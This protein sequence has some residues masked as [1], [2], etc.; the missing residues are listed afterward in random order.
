MNSL[1][2]LTNRFQI[3]GIVKFEEGPGGLIR[4]VVTNRHA[5][6][7]IYLHG[8]HV[9]T[10]QPR[11][12]RPVLFMSAAS[13]FAAG[14]PI[15]G[16]VPVI[17]PWFGPNPADAAAPAH[18]L[19]RLVDWELASVEEGRLVFGTSA[20]GCRLTYRVTIGA[21]L[22]LELEV[23]NIGNKTV[24]FE[25]ALHTYFAASDCRHCS[26]TGLEGTAYQSKVGETE[27]SAPIRFTRETDRLYLN[28]QA[29]CV[30]HD[31][32]WQRRIIVEKS[33]SDCTV[34]WNPWIAKAKAMPDFGDD[35][36]LG[37]VCIEAVNARAFAVHL[38][39]GN[40]HSLRQVIRV[41]SAAG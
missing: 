8:A 6:A 41:E 1:E 5:E 22:T 14:K 13:C 3:P 38:A 39:P 23:R 12:H 34:V 15:R 32:G 27:G 26:V 16:G 28:T 37:M 31:P 4:A 29:T 11:G 33:G 19:V 40:S 2:Q 10:F 24:N 30:L 17:F 35:E 25:E 21:T 20:A 36:W 9:A 7:T 18:G